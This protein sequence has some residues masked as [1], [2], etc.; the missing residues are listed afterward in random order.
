M[1]AREVHVSK[2]PGQ[3]ANQMDW[4]IA[5]LR[6]VNVGGKHLLAMKDL[7]AMVEAE[8]GRDVSTYIQSGNV[9]FRATPSV[10]ERLPSTLGRILAD[11]FALDVTVMTRSAAALR[12]VVESNPFV[13]T[14]ADPATLHVAFLAGAPT[15][16]RIAG[17]DPDRSP[18]DRFEVRGH[19]VYLHLPNGMARTRLTNAYLDA[20]LGTTSTVRNWRTV[21]HLLDRVGG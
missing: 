13:S 1:T 10:V 12:L 19:V 7:V 15:A 4:H 2:R 17:L 9:V 6:G 11:R 8:G 20:K 18:P 21:V 3:A 14:G 5:L 16:A